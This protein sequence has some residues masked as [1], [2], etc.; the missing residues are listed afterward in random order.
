MELQNMESNVQVRVEDAEML[1]S[2]ERKR[3][4][5]RERNRLSGRRETSTLELLRT[6]RSKLASAPLRPFQP[7]KEDSS[8]A[9]NANE[10]EV[11]STFFNFHAFDESFGGG[12]LIL[13]NKHC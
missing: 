10:D 9:E 4:E 12:S 8:A 6:F 2:F 13:V 7:P 3:Q 5:F 1:S 11:C